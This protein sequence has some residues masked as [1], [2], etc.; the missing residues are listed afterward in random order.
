MLGK[1]YQYFDIKTIFLIAIAI[2]EIGSLICGVAKNSTTLIV[3]RV[4]IGLGAAGVLAGCYTI[5]AFVVPAHKRPAFTGF[6]GA[7]YVI[8]SV[9]GPLVGGA[10]TD[11][12]S[13]LWW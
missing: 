10:F 1:A 5:I 3:G 7:T 2:F 4:I 11:G 8:A 9:I 13:W 12:P 6:I